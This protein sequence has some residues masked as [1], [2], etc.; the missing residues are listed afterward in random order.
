[1]RLRDSR[2]PF[3][4]NGGPRPLRLTFSPRD[5]FSPCR[6]KNTGSV[7][8]CEWE[9]GPSHGI[10]LPGPAY[11]LVSLWLLEVQS[12]LS[13]HRGPKGKGPRVNGAGGGGGAGEQRAI[14][15][16]G[17]G[18]A[19]RLPGAHVPE[20]RLWPGG[21]GKAG[22]RREGVAPSSGTALGTHQRTVNGAPLPPPAESVLLC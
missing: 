15:L 6:G 3:P 12:V 14:R 22:G 18:T 9:A 21:K 7:S 20:G 5:P 2:S 1:M 4:K 11:S 13:A 16:A 10:L 8:R 17:E 19:Q